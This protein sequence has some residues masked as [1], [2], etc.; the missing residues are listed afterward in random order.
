MELCR[1]IG[2]NIELIDNTIKAYFSQV[3][4]ISTL[5]IPVRCDAVFHIW[6]VSDFRE[7]NIP[8]NNKK[9]ADTV[10]VHPYQPDFSQRP[11]LHGTKKLYLK[12]Q[13]DGGIEYNSVEVGSPGACQ[14]LSSLFITQNL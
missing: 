8:A 3:G 2:K 12:Y 14:F 10:L 7:V 6:L 5:P 1:T 9:R 13:V 4:I 11:N